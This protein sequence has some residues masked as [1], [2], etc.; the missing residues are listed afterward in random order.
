MSL[1]IRSRL[2]SSHKASVP[3]NKLAAPQRRPHR[4]THARAEVITRA[5]ACTHARV[6]GHTRAH[7][8]QTRSGEEN[9]EGHSITGRD[10]VRMGMIM[11]PR[12]V[13]KTTTTTTNI[14]SM[15]LVSVLLL[16]GLQHAG[17]ATLARAS[18]R[19][20]LRVPRRLNHTSTLMSQH[21][22]DGYW[23]MRFARKSTW[24]PLEVR[25]CCECPP[26]QI[27]HPSPV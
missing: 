12:D 3:T 23:R 2:L 24:T 7:M 27:D 1:A 22:R 16:S 19:Q 6:N 5:H 9:D 17:R 18:T 14:Y 4:V 8:L 25:N 10:R 11:Q 26:P 20:Q 13:T 15:I 21:W